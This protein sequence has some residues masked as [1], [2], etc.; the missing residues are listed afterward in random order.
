M[1]YTFCFTTDLLIL[2]PSLIMRRRKL[3]SLL[4][5]NPPVVIDGISMETKT[6]KYKNGSMHRVGRN[7]YLRL[8]LLF[9]CA[10]DCVVLIKFDS[11]WVENHKDYKDWED[12]EYIVKRIKA[13]SGKRYQSNEVV[14]KGHVFVVGDNELCSTDSRVFGSIP[15]DAIVG[16]LA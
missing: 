2:I 12:T 5:R 14:P 11:S 7:I 3:I 9:G 6:S 4:K 13:T 10:T 8:R 1:L 15:I 16:K